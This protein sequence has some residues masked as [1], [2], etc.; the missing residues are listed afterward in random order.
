MMLGIPALSVGDAMLRL[1]SAVFLNPEDVLI[2]LC[3]HVLSRQAYLFVITGILSGNVYA[4]GFGY[5]VGWILC[6]LVITAYYRF[7]RWDA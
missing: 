3:T 1:R 4:V 5:P 2:A 7:S 6:A